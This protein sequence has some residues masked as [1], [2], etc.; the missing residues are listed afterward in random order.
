MRFNNFS[1]RIFHTIATLPVT[2]HYDYRVLNAT[3]AVR[4]PIRTINSCYM[5]KLATDFAPSYLANATSSPGAPSA[6]S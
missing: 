1:R 2:L 5:S 3:S 6:I 4:W